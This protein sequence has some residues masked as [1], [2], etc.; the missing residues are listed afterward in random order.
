MHIQKNPPNKQLIYLAVLIVILAAI[1][2]LQSCNSERKALKP[3]KS[4]LSDID[5]NFASKKKDLLAAIVDSKMPNK[6]KKETITKYIQGQSILVKDTSGNKYLRDYYERQFEGKLCFTGEQLD[7]MIDVAIS[8][9]TPNV[10]YRTDTLDNSTTETIIDTTGNYYKY[11]EN[12]LLKKNY[13]ECE[14]DVETLIEASKDLLN[15]QHSLSYLA[16]RFF[17]EIWHRYWWFFV[18]LGLG[19]GG[20]FWIKNQYKIPFLNK[21]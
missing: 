19:T 18:L 11:K 3:Y 12:E 4:V 9:I 13:N 8:Q 17:G 20:Y 14:K 5:T 16:K 2:G 15:K 21:K 6:A 10:I 7:S 1:I